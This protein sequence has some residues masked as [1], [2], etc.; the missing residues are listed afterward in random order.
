MIQKQT[1]SWFVLA[2]VIC[3]SIAVSLGET[4]T[5]TIGE[6]LVLRFGYRGRRRG[7]TYH[8]SKD[9]QTFVPERLRVFQRFE[10]LSF[11]E[12]TDTDAGEYHL[13]VDGRRVHYSQTINVLG[14]HTMYVQIVMMLT[15]C[16]GHTATYVYTSYSYI[17][18]YLVILHV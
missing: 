13:V 12:V 10:R 15:A 6:P 7:V 4:I 5:A 8:F 11:V 17:V 2:A 18:V 3:C 14:M 16:G 9:G 1:W